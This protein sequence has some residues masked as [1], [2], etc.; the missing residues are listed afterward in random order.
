[1]RLVS[2]VDPATLEGEARAVADSGIAQYGQAL[3]TWRAI[4]HS[5]DLFAAYLPF[6]R[7]V[8]GPGRLD[9][10]TKDLSAL[11]VGS[12]NRCAYTVSHRTAS[13]RRN[14]VDER[15]LELVVAGE[16]RGFDD[17]LRA[18]LELTRELTLEPAR[19]APAEHPTIIDDALRSRLQSLFDERELVELTMS[20]S[21]WNGLARFHRV[22]GFEFDMPPAP[23]GVAPH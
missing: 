15:E 18:A 12:L 13:A 1:M 23:E 22:M 9:A 7:A 8:A 3:E 4:M 20:I 2:L 6:L 17:R 19:L 14:G 16:W 11:L 10:R 5:P 21:V